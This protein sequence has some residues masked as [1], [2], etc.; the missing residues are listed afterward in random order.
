MKER[1]SKSKSAEAVK[2]GMAVHNFNS[3]APMVDRRQRQERL[4]RLAGLYSGKQQRY[5]LK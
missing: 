3:S 5:C 1:G 4:W 2:A